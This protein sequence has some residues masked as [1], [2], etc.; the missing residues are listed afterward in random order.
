MLPRGVQ[1]V[2]CRCGSFIKRSN[3]MIAYN[4]YVGSQYINL[5]YICTTYILRI[6]SI[7]TLTAQCSFNSAHTPSTPTLGQRLLHHCTFQSSLIAC[8]QLRLTDWFC[9]ITKHT[10]LFFSKSYIPQ[11]CILFFLL[12]VSFCCGKALVNFKKIK[13]T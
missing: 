11:V 9:L 5:Y 8:V 10:V 6:C 4:K 2:L 13:N 3:T 1:L 7:Y 12:Y